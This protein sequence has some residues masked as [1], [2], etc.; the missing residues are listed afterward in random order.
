MFFAIGPRLLTRSP[1][2]S[3]ISIIGELLARS[4]ALPE[5]PR[6]MKR[7]ILA[8]VLRFL[9]P[10]FP[11]IPMLMQ[12]T[13]P[14]S[15]VPGCRVIAHETGK[16]GSERSIALRSHGI[17]ASTGPEWTI[18]DYPTVEAEREHTSIGSFSRSARTPTTCFMSVTPPEMSLSRDA[19]G[20][21]RTCRVCPSIQ[22]ANSGRRG[23]TICHSRCRASLSR[24]PRGWTTTALPARSRRPRSLQLSA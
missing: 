2:R 20:R 7:R 15:T 17:R 24:R 9:A 14:G 16:S 3:S 10:G 19:G 22:V 4:D 11:G 8:R 18:E 12:A 13:S 1:P 6:R 5:G 23:R 21:G